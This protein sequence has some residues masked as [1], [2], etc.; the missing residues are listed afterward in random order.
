V[1]TLQDKYVDLGARS[2][3]MLKP[4]SGESSDGTAYVNQKGVFTFNKAN[5]KLT[6]TDRRLNT[7]IEDLPDT[8][9]LVKFKFKT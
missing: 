8:D 4:S 7:I 5:A 9:F 2:L 6:A 3:V 1:I